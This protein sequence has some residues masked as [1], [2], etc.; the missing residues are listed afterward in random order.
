MKLALSV[1]F[2]YVV[3]W[4]I[5]D[6]D[7]VKTAKFTDQCDICSDNI[8]WFPR[9]DV[10]KLCAFRAHLDQRVLPKNWVKG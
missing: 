2:G 6:L 10:H 8:G 4:V 9:G 3:G 1:M 7:S 5:R